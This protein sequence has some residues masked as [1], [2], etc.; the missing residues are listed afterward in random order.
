MTDGPEVLPISVGRHA[1]PLDE[2]VPEEPRAYSPMHGLSTE[3]TEATPREE[4]PWPEN[5]LLPGDFIRAFTAGVTWKALLVVADGA[6]PGQGVT[7]TLSR[8]AEEMAGAAF[9]PPGGDPGVPYPVWSDDSGLSLDLSVHFAGVGVRGLSAGRP[10]EPGWAALGM[11]SRDTG[12]RQRHHGVLVIDTLNP[13]SLYRPFGGPVQPDDEP[14][15]LPDASLPPDGPD[16]G[17]VIVADLRRAGTRVVNAASLWRYGCRTVTSAL[18]DPARP[19]S[20]AATREELR[21][22]R[23]LAYVDPALGLGLVVQVDVARRPWC[24][25]G[26]VIE[27]DAPAGQATARMLW[28]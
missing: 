11:S 9:L 8:R 5:A 7:G 28:P 27:E 19:D 14:S 13:Q 20:R 26:F 1:K 23:H 3:P 4:E 17:V 22:L 18:Y 2:P 16:A 15:A 21:A 6:F 25:L 10:P 12:F 24:P